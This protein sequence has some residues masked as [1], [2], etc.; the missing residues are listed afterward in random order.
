MPL[1]ELIYKFV[2]EQAIAYPLS[3]TAT[4]LQEPL[5]LGLACINV[6][7]LIE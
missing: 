7:P 1:L 2:E 5:I 4:V 3:D 6:P